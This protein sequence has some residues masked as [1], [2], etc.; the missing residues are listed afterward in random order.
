MQDR[1]ETLFYKV[2]LDNFVEMA[3][4]IYT[5]TVSPLSDGRLLLPCQGVKLQFEA[6][7]GDSLC[8]GAPILLVFP[9]CLYVFILLLP[10]R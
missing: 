5:P 9:G 8:H 4:I 10:S 7:K 6:Q 2:L 3:P 1:N